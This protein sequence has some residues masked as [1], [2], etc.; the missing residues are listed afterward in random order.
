MTPGCSSTVTVLA[1]THASGHRLLSRHGRNLSIFPAGNHHLDDRGN[2]LPRNRLAADVND[3][4]QQQ[5]QSLKFLIIVKI[6]NYRCE[7]GPALLRIFVT[8][9]KQLVP[10]KQR[11]RFFAFA[12]ACWFFRQMDD[13]VDELAGL[14]T[15]LFGVRELDLGLEVIICD[16]FLD[17]EVRT[18]GMLKLADPGTAFANDPGDIFDWHRGHFI[19]WARRIGSLI[20]TPAMAPTRQYAEVASFAVTRGF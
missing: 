8:F 9:G 11:R 18:T 2:L 14:A 15:R 17:P 4:W 3:G 20:V 19:V 7:R 16:V 1:M 5:C 13:R 10:V 12:G 6:V